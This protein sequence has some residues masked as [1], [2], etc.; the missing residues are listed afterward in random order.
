MANIREPKNK[1]NISRAS[2]IPTI[3]KKH[4]QFSTADQQ[5]TKTHVPRGRLP[6]GAGDLSRNDPKNAPN[7]EPMVAPLAKLTAC[8]GTP[9][10]K[11]VWGVGHPQKSQS[12]S[13]GRLARRAG[14]ADVLSWG[15]GH[16]WSLGFCDSG[17]LSTSMDTSACPR[18]F[19]CLS[20]GVFR[21]PFGSP[22]GAFVML[23]GDLC[24]Q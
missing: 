5:Y 10:Q 22:S 14:S 4:A 7:M 11:G 8:G 16:T 24:P 3:H 6:P 19:V 20:F 13:G 9:L 18:I 21:A 15:L 1:T 12:C 23:L 2:L 17:L